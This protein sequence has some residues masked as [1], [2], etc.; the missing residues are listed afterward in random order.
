MNDIGKIAALAVVAALCAVVV[1]KQSPEIAVVLA[2]TA[3][4]MV[5]FSCIQSL[6]KVLDFL[7]EL[8]EFG[9]IS[10]TVIMPVV[11]VSGIAIV[12]KV[13]AEICKDAKES[14][15]AGFVETAGTVCALF[16]VLPLMTAVLST[17][18]GFL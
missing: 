12:T 14:G 16:A 6:S 1:K 11:K 9:G 10:Q 8:A 15:L 4:A 17:L 18:S 5:L 7:Y 13:T 2:L 3:G